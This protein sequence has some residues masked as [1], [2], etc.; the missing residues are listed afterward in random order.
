MTREVQVRRLLENG[1][2]EVFMERPTACSGDCHHCAGGCTAAKEIMVVR[3]RNLIGARPGDRVLLELSARQMLKI[4]LLTYFVPIVLFFL[5]WFL[6]SLAGLA[7]WCGG[8]GF[9]LGIGFI[10]WFNRHVE[11]KAPVQYRIVGYV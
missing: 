2:A 9:V 3:A 7:P 5:G 6:G 10:L 1:Y 8:A 11:K 4:S